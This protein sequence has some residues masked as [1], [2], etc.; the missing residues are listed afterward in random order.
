MVFL[1]IL[2]FSLG[3]LCVHFYYRV[4]RERFFI[5]V[6]IHALNRYLADAKHGISRDAL[7]LDIGSGDRPHLRADIICDRYEESWERTHKLQRDRPLVLGDINALPF[8]DKAID[9]VCCQH[10]ME[11][12][13]SPEDA[14][15]EMERIGKRGLIRT[16]SPLAEKLFARDVHRWMVSNEQ[17]AGVETIVHRQ[18]AHAIWDEDLTSTTWSLSGFWHF[19][20]RNIEKMETTYHWEGQVHYQIERLENAPWDGEPASHDIEIPESKLDRTNLRQV[21]TQHIGAFYR[22]YYLGR[23]RTIDWEK[24]LCCPVCKADVKV[25]NT[26]ITCQGCGRVYPMRDGVPVMLAEES[27]ILADEAKLPKGE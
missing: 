15:A 2:A 4:L 27:V 18:K 8:K 25:T 26:D 12:L 17:I 20:G 11:H 5:D 10:V 22:Y 24:I 1:V 3:A 21:F 7:M 9:V 14:Y 16:P 23:P 6:A 19:F 13:A